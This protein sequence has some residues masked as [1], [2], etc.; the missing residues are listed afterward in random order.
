MPVFQHPIF[1]G[2]KNVAL[3]AALLLAPVAHAEV[4]GNWGTLTIGDAQTQSCN[5]TNCSTLVGT[6]L[7]GA[8]LPAAGA[9][10]H[11]VT[12]KVD[13]ESAAVS[14]IQILI[15][16]A[17]SIATVSYTL[18]S[19]PVDLALGGVPAGA[20]LLA[21]GAA[22][23]GPP[24][25]FVLGYSG[26][27]AGVQYFVQIQGQVTGT[28]ASYASQIALTAVPLPPAVFLLAAALAGL[29]GFARVRWSRETA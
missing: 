25:S 22:Q 20:T 3:S 8:K 10:S 19:N 4:V 21:T 1:S 7:A 6:T 14:S 15:P 16:A 11:Q 13:L 2:L 29:I 18:W 5:Q 24:A 27:V 26:L 28:N 23:V 12:F 9:F 17:F